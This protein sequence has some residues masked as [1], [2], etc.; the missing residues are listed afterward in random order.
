[1]CRAVRALAGALALAACASA[2]KPVPAHLDPSN[3]DAPEA[4]AI[5]MA[6]SPAASPKVPRYACPMHPEV[7]SD[8][9]GDKCPKCGMKLTPVEPEP[10]KPEEPAGQHQHHDH[11]GG[12]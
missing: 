12:R 3:P 10:A 7:Q 1:M 9:P 5:A 8:K 6:A 4:P 2:P 11:G